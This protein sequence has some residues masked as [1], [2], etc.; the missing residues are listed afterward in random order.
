MTLKTLSL[1]Q[2][3]L[4]VVGILTIVVLATSQA[5]ASSAVKWNIKI[6][7][8]TRLEYSIDNIIGTSKW[9]R[10]RE[11]ETLLDIARDYD[12]G[13]NELRDLYPKINPWVPPEGKEIIIPS[14]W[15]LPDTLRKGIVI[16]VPEMRLFYFIT[17]GNETVVKTFPI[18]IGDI[19]FETP[20]G[21]YTI[22]SKRTNPAW[23]IPPSLQSKY[24]VKVMPPGPENPLGAYWIRLAN[25]MYGIHGTDIPWSVGRLVTHGCIRLYPEDI[26]VLFPIVKHG[27]RVEIIYDPVK[28]ALINE[29]V[30]IEVH[31]DVYGKIDDFVAYAV[32]LLNEK[33]L[34][35]RINR[36]KF[37]QALKRRDGIPVDITGNGS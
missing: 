17:S 18:G 12:I 10:I 14:R 34:S 2:F 20:V 4:F 11:K 3:F 35:Q 29:W 24:D 21:I 9:H 19:D 32:R 1:S 16:N 28:F 27:T 5:I 15:I 6:G 7:N 33:G 23:Y 31:D 8:P 37:L 26:E 22:G 13:F 25:T 30:Y 36:N